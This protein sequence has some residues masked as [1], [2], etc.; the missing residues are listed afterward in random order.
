MF[1]D[2]DQQDDAR[3]EA[4][5]AEYLRRIDRGEDVDQ[6]QIIAEHAEFAKPLREY[7]ETAAKIAFLA[8]QPDVTRDSGARSPSSSPHLDV[9]RYFGDYELLDVIARGGMGVVYRARQVSLNRVVALKMILAGKLADQADVSRFHAE[10]EAAAILDHPGI[11]PIYEIGEHKGQHYFSMGYVDGESLSDRIKDGP[12]PPR[13]AAAYM[14]KIAEA[15]AFAHQHGVIHRDLK[16]SNVL[17]DGAGELKVSDFGLAKRVQSDSDLTATGQVLGTPSYMPPEQASGEVDDI[18]ELSD[19]YSIGATCYCL[20]TGNPPFAAASAV[21]TLRQ[22]V[23]TEP[24]PPTDVNPDVDLD[25]QTITLKCLEKRPERRYASATELA[26]ELDRF[27]NGEPIHA[28]P[29]SAIERLWRWC[30]RKPRVAGFYA[31]ATALILLLTIGGPIVAWLQAELRQE[32]EDRAL[33]ERKAMRD[34]NTQRQ[35]A[36]TMR[37]KEEQKRQEAVALRKRTSVLP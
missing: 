33:A 5:L 25:L 17:L 7:F 6:D 1:G 12:L 9:I 8:G 24:I 2:E 26:A 35:L 13:E 16:P 14:L 27:L 18:T 29:I 11:V 36:E 15:V 20:L 4:V 28:R 10:A 31:T 22:V 23:E 19:I 30:K 3:F 21:E 32:A 37:E 34:A